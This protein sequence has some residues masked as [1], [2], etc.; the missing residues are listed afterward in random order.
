MSTDDGKGKGS[1]CGVTTVKKN[2][3]A[4]SVKKRRSDYTKSCD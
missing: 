1:V 3:L 2:P 4:V